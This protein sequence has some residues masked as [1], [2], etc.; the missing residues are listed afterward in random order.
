MNT[1]VLIK[2]LGNNNINWYEYYYFIVTS[3]FGIIMSIGIN[4]FI[5]VYFTTY[6]F[7]D[8]DIL[9]RKKSDIL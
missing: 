2:T 7:V 9:K 8:D 5:K 6:T 3:V 4:W 1:K